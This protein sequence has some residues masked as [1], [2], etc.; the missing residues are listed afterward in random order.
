MA[1]YVGFHGTDTEAAD[2][3]LSSLKFKASP[4][5]TSWLGPG[6]YFFSQYADALWWCTHVKGLPEDKFEILQVD[7]T[8]EK[9]ID[10]CANPD[11]AQNFK[12]FCDLVTNRC[13]RLSNGKRRENY[14]P[15]ALKLMMQR[16]K[17]KPDMI[18]GAFSQNRNFWFTNESDKEKFPLVIAQV[19][20]CVL[21]KN[22]IRNIRAVS[23]DMR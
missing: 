11:D 4:P 19:Q 23:N 9:V 6:V 22:C 16:T 3:I 10:L 12:K 15:L 7:L 1:K 5:E 8:P 20:Y 18:I 17:D 13:E 14:V 2:K 21:N